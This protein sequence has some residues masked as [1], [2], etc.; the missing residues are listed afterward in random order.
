[1]KRFHS[2]RALHLTCVRLQLSCNSSSARRTATDELRCLAAKRLMSRAACAG[3]TRLPIPVGF[4]VELLVKSR[5]P[6]FANEIRPGTFRSD[7]SDCL[8]EKLVSFL[9]ARV[10]APCGY[11]L[12]ASRVF[13]CTTRAQTHGA[14]TNASSNRHRHGALHSEISQRKKRCFQK[15]GGRASHR[16]SRQCSDEAIV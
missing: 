2:S 8:H 7:A 14:K 3:C 6:M 4:E 10:S 9:N 16:R 5:C 1:M 12:K 11:K 15:T 13:V